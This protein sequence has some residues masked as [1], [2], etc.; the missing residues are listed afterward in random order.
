MVTG[1]MCLVSDC[2]YNCY[3]TVYCNFLLMLQENLLFCNT[4]KSSIVLEV[5]VYTLN[6]DN[7]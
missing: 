7:G 1:S 2:K 5:A 4:T 3:D 6:N